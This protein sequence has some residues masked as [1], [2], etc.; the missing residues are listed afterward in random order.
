MRSDRQELD[1]ALRELAVVGWN[2]KHFVKL[3]D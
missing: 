1:A 2:K 3:K